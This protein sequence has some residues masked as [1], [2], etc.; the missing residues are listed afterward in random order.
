MLEFT[1]PDGFIRL[2]ASETSIQIRL[3]YATECNFVGQSIKGYYANDM[4][5][6]R[7]ETFNALS[8]AQ[9]SFIEQ[10]YTLVVLDAYR[11]LEQAV[12]ESFKGWALNTTDIKMK[13][14][15]YPDLT[16]P[17][18]FQKGYIL[19]NSNHC[20]GNAVDVALME[21]PSNLDLIPTCQTGFICNPI[22]PYDFIYLYGN[23]LL[24]N[25]VDCPKLE[26]RILPKSNRTIPF[27]Q[28]E[29]F[30]DLGGFFDFFDP[31]SWPNN[32]EISND[33]H[34]MRQLL[35]N[36]MQK[37]GLFVLDEEIWHYNLNGAVGESY[38]FDVV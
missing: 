32:T 7:E 6:L 25:I 23:G 20:T 14:I 15:F 1:V 12:R 10:G 38:N 35:V 18:L 2:H 21:I 30:V 29:Y 5:I 9:D 37:H 19:E 26:Y 24:G 34:K 27:Y 22:C 11:P 33:Q 16:K 13:Y 8:K 17:E 3:M 28:Y 4:L 31:V 36:T